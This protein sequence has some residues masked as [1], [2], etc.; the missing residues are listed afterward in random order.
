MKQRILKLI[1]GVATFCLCNNAMAT[2]LDFTDSSLISSLSTISNGY[3]GSIDG[4]GFSLTSED[5]TVNFNES[6]DG[7]SRSGCQ[8]TGGVLQCDTDGAGITDDEI[9]GFQVSDQTLTLTFD[10]AVS[11]TGFYFLDLYINPNGS[12]A[13]EQATISIDGVLFDT[14]DAIGATGDGGYADLLTTPILAQ[15]IQLTA[16]NNPSFWDDFN[17]DYSF[18]GV[19]VNTNVPEPHT[20]LLLGAGLVGMAGVKRF[21]KVGSV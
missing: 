17:N 13:K 11:L 8:S 18:A 12:G 3:S 15:T 4:I 19:D 10:S 5:G 9:T 21:K 14:V 16:V 2:L 6:Y 20:I 1:T 7:S